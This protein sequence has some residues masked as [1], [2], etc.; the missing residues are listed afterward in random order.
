MAKNTF[1]PNTKIKSAEVNEN[2]DG[3]YDLSFMTDEARQHLFNRDLFINSVINSDFISWQEGTTRTTPNDDVYVAD[4][5]NNLQE[6]NGAWTYSRST[7]VPTGIG[8]RF[9]LKAANVTLNNQCA[10]VFFLENLDA[11]ALAGKT[12]SLSFYAKTTS[13]KLINNLR[14]SILAWTGTADAVT[15]DVISA[16]ASD[17]TDPTFATNWTKEIAGSNLALTTSWQRFTV[18]NIA[19]DTASTNNYALIIWVDD[20]TIAATDEFYLT[21]VQINVG[22]EAQPIWTPRSVQGNLAD[23]QR[24]IWRS[25]TG[26]YRY[27]VNNVQRN[28]VPFPV[29]MRATPTW[30]WSPTGSGIGTNSTTATQQGINYDFQ[31]TAAGIGVVDVGTFNTQLADARL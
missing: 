16:W 28:F 26:S 20:G 9:S 11:L 10:L 1:V 23:C 31:F 12:V 24:Y 4:V 30:S 15:S 5:W 7:D 25:T 3:A 22:A 19:L 8:A 18:E 21:A 13:A 2:F 17:G 27:Y 6:A 29:E 14:A